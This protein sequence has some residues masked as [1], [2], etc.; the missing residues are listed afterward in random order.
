MLLKLKFLSLLVCTL[1]FS[2]H[3]KNE[4][5]TIIANVTIDYQGKSNDLLIRIKNFNDTLYNIKAYATL[6]LK[7]VDID[8]YQTKYK[9]NYLSDLADSSVNVIFKN[10]Y[11]KYQI[12]KFH[13]FLYSGVDTDNLISCYTASDNYCKLNDF[14]GQNF[15]TIKSLKNRKTR[16]YELLLNMGAR[17]EI[18]I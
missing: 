11:H 16:T 18:K 17:V 5:Q 6:G 8:C 10:I 14:N 9:L 7:L 4:D 12:F 2:C 15:G 1:L 3:V 13:K